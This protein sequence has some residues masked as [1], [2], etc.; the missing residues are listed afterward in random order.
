MG[1]GRHRAILQGH[2]TVW[3]RCPVSKELG[4]NEASKIIDLFSSLSYLSVSF[5][6]SK[7]SSSFWETGS[8]SLY[9]IQGQEP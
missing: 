6:Q 5:F 9:H 8:L 3:I 7:K 1:P 2:T 4:A